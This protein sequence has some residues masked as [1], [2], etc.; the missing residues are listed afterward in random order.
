MIIVT[1]KRQEIVFKEEKIRG[2]SAKF[3][4]KNHGNTDKGNKAIE[5]GKQGRKRDGSSCAE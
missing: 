1:R 5:N 4:G 3:R 2:R